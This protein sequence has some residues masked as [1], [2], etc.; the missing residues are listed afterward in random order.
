MLGYGE[1]LGAEE[2]RIERSGFTF[3]YLR[4]RSASIDRSLHTHAAANFLLPLDHGFFSEAWKYD[5][6][7][8]NLQIIYTPA[9]ISHRDS[10]ERLLGRF[11]TISIAD[12]LLNDTR[13]IVGVLDHPLALTS[14]QALW[15]AHQLAASFIDRRRL[16]CDYEALGM[17]LLHLVRRDATGSQGVDAVRC[18]RQ[19]VEILHQAGAVEIAIAD[20]ARRCGVH[21]AYFSR[22][23]HRTMRCSPKQYVRRLRVARAAERLRHSASSLAEVAA[24]AGFCDQSHMARSFQ[25]VLGVTP[26][27]YRDSNR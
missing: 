21:P 12:D 10:M 16:Q 7:S 3:C 15:C 5:R 23:F 11:V 8:E 17:E 4:S 18:V 14:P 9:G 20:L 22:V 24:A 19:A 2:Q 26:G 6:C 27:Q 1:F 13:E 25:S